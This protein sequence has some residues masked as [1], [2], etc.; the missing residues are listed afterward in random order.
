MKFTVLTLDAAHRIGAWEEDSG[1]RLT[2]DQR[3]AL[4]SR[5]LAR[6]DG[7]AGAA[8]PSTSEARS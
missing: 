8:P 5:L 6:E 3:G 1:I 2:P 7:D 4:L